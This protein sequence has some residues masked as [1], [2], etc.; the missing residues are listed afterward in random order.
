[1]F[2]KDILS[3]YCIIARKISTT[4]TNILKRLQEEIPSFMITHGILAVTLYCINTSIQSFLLFNTFVHVLRYM[5]S[6]FIFS[7]L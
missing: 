6:Y 1:M 5:C 3:I 7:I 4:I 2:F